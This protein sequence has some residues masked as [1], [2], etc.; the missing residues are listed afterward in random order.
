[1][2]RVRNSRRCARTAPGWH[3]TEAKLHN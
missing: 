3:F 1:M 2:L